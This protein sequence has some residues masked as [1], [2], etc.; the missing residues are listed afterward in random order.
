LT[1]VVLPALYSIWFRV[2]PSAKRYSSLELT[3]HPII[4]DRITA[5]YKSFDERPPLIIT[6]PGIFP[7][8][9]Y[10]RS[11]GKRGPQWANHGRNLRP[12]HSPYLQGGVDFEYLRYNYFSRWANPPEPKMEPA[13]IYHFTKGEILLPRYR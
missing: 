11:F 7:Q 13:E 8:R 3:T 9:I 6:P 10:T 4:G 12:A 2:I 1:L 5:C